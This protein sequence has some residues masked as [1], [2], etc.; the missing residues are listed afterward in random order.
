M[1]NWENKSNTNAQNDFKQFGSFIEKY[2]LDGELD[3]I[4]SLKILLLIKTKIKFQ[5]YLI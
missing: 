1:E 3:K 5:S 4:Y 2:V